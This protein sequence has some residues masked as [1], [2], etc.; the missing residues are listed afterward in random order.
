MDTSDMLDSD[1]SK[2]QILQPLLCLHTIYGCCQ[3]LLNQLLA[4]TVLTDKRSLKSKGVR[5]PHIGHLN[6]EKYLHWN[7]RTIC[8]QASIYILLI[9]CSHRWKAYLYFR[10]RCRGSRTVVIFPAACLNCAFCS[11]HSL[12][13]ELI[14]YSV[15]FRN[16]ILQFVPP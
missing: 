14:V 4:C 7:L 9:N 1:V 11:Y 13:K 6:S 5:R 16:N 3:A 12:K 10:K 15:M 2:F 8:R